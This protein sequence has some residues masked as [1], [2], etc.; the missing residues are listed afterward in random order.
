[1]KPSIIETSLEHRL[2]L[3]SEGN[4]WAVLPDRL[5]MLAHGLAWARDKEPM[6]LAPQRT[7]DFEARADRLRPRAV[8]GSVLEARRIGALSGSYQT[9]GQGSVAVIPISGIILQHTDLFGTSTD[10]AGRAFDAALADPA[11]QTVLLWIDSPG[12]G[13]AGVEELSRK[14]F[15]G[16]QQ[17]RVVAA[18][19]SLA[20]SAAL[21]IGASANEI[22][23]TPSGQAGSIGVFTVHVDTSKALEMA[24]IRVSL[25]SS[26]PGKVGGNEF[27]PLD[28]AAAADLQ[29]K[30][31]AYGDMF[32][33][34][35]AR[36]RGVAPAT[37]ARTY[38]QGRM[39]LAGDAKAVGLV[40]RVDT[41]QNVLAG[42][43]SESKPTA[44]MR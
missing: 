36:G 39:L 34:A 43:V 14:I 12:G 21:W 27:Q 13:V 29:A 23:I 5:P 1:M 30:V 26:S 24:G 10:G 4:P 28:N 19:D 22:V 17:K 25:V 9:T 35:V 8:P 6:A 44:R 38:G 41:F 32:T 40:D 7:L 15:A 3:L 33:A 37:V 42:L 18:I 11:V 20:A 31:T 16:R 2:A